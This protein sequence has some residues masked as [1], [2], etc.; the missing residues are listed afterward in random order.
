MTP[1]TFAEYAVSGQPCVFN[2]LTGEL[3]PTG[4]IAPPGYSI[5]ITNK[6]FGPGLIFRALGPVGQVPEA[7]A[8]GW[9]EASTGDYIG[10]AGDGKGTTLSPPEPLLPLNP[11]VGDV[12]TVMVQPSYGGPPL[13]VV[14]RV[15]S[16]ANGVTKTTLV[17][18]PEAT[19][20]AYT[21]EF[22]GEFKTHIFGDVKPDGTVD[23][24]MWTRTSVGTSP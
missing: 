5:R 18:R 13:K 14:N 23:A 16:V 20:R 12:R 7:N 6:A 9:L 21:M 15:I 24:L 2:S 8:G 4:N 19:P 3:T 10:E 11:V 1:N 22:D 17:E